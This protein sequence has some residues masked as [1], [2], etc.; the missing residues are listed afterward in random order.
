MRLRREAVRTYWNRDLLDHHGRREREQDAR[1]AAQAATIRAAAQEVEH[2]AAISDD[3]R[4]R[5]VVE[6]FG[7]GGSNEEDEER[8]Y[9]ILT[10][11]QDFENQFD[12]FH[13]SFC[14]RDIWIYE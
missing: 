7:D 6:L 11:G 5:R 8:T 1:L 3:A 2:V 9:P 4:A 14:F 13:C 12:D 10:E